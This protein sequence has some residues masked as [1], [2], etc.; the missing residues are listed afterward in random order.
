MQERKTVLLIDETHPILLKKLEAKGY[1]IDFKPQYTYKDVLNNISLYDCIVVRSKVKIDKAVIDRAEKLKCIA[2]SGAGMDA[3]DVEY[4]QSKGIKCLN[5]P[6]G[7]R[8]AVGEHTL[9][10]LLT[11]F[12]KI[13]FADSQVRQ[14]LWQREENRGIEIKGKTIGIIGYG[15]MGQAFAKR[16]SGFD[17]KVIAYDKYKH[18]FSDNFATECSL[19]EIFTYSDVLSLHVPL[20]EDTF[21]LVCSGFINNFAKPFYLLNTSRGKVVSLHD[22]VE[23]MQNGKIKGCG[24]DVSETE[25]YNQQI[26]ADSKLQADVDT[27]YKMKNTVFTPHVAGWTVESYYKLADY[28]ADKI[29]ATLE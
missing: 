4:A 26:I 1:A 12:N 23:A 8:D 14:G 21:H 16:L 28:L 2:R 25:N 9:G 22:L 7:N 13:N 15:N 3:I 5:S 19:E 27:L 18:G 11:L 29:I 24:L 20:T 17:C 6:E 10:L